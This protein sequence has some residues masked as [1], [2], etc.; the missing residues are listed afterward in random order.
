MLSNDFSFVLIAP[1]GTQHHASSPI[2]IDIKL[3]ELRKIYGMNAAFRVRAVR[4]ELDAR[5]VP[6]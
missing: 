4:R 5:R 3:C 1:D 6:A 2:E